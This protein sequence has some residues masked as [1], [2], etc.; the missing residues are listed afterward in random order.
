MASRRARDDLGRPSLIAKEGKTERGLRL[1]ELLAA[2][3][4]ATD[5]AHDVP[6]ESALRD[7]LLALIPC[8][9]LACQWSG[10]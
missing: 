4:V 2:V 10:P 5:L 8:S 1:A 7:S 9:A 3:S 6:A